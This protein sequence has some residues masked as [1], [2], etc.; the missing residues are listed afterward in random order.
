MNC[1]Q[2]VSTHRTLQWELIRI[3]ILPSSGQVPTPALTGLSWAWF[4]ISSI[5]YYKKFWSK[6]SWSERFWSKKIWV[7][8]IDPIYDQIKIWSKRFRVQNYFYSKKIGGVI[9]MSL[10][11]SCLRAF[12]TF[13]EHLKKLIIFTEGGVPPSPFAE[14]SAKKF[15]FLTLP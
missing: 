3:R 11:F 6:N 12:W 1:F 9:F 13:S 4:L 5:F 7:K 8:N 2:N 15:N 10:V 14:N